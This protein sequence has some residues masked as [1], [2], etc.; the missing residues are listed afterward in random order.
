M[1]GD[2][3]CFQDKTD[4][5]WQLFIIYVAKGCEPHESNTTYIIWGYYE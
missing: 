4:K 3:R 1:K 2:K 5:K